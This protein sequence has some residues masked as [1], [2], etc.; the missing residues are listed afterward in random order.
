MRLQ[1]LF[2]L[3]A[4][5]ALP[6]IAAARPASPELMQHVNP[7]GSVTEYRLHGNEYFSYITDAE[8]KNI[9][10]YSNGRLEQAFRNGKALRFQEADIEMLRSEL[11]AEVQ[12]VSKHVGHRMAD[13]VAMGADKGRTTFPTVPKN[14]NDVVRSCVILLEYADKPYSSTDPKEQFTRL[15]NEEGY[16]D[17]GSKGSA[18]DYFKSASN[19]VFAPQFDVYGPVKL[20]HTSAWYTN[21]E[22]VDTRLPLNDKNARFGVAI[23]EAMEALDDEVDFS[24]YDYDN[25]GIIDNIFFFFSGYGQADGGGETTIW[26]HQSDYRRFTLPYGCALDLPRQ[27]RDGVELQCYACSNELNGSRQIP[28]SERPYLDGIGAFCH[29]FGHV[30]GLPDLYD[31]GY[32]GCKTPG[33]YSIMDQGSY[34]DLSTCPPTYS[35]YEQW[36]CRWLEYTDAEDGETY[37]LNPLTQSDR[38]A[39][40]IRVPQGGGS[41]YTEYYVVETRGYDSWDASVPEHGILIWRVNFNY[42]VWRQNKVNSGR[43]PYVELIGPSDEYTAWPGDFEDFVYLTPQ[44]NI[45]VP[46]CLR[47]PL[48]VTL[49]NISYDRGNGQ[50]SFEYNKCTPLTEAPVLAENPQVRPEDR[51]IWLKWDK[52]PGATDYHLTV[53]R[54]DSNDN[55]FTVDGLQESSV[56]NVTEYF[57]KNITTNQWTQTFSAY[58]RP[59]NGVP[60]AV[61]S[62]VINF[63]PAE[64]KTVDIAGVDNVAGE[65][66]VIFGGNG[67]ITAPEGA[68]VYNLSGVECGLTDLPEGVY[69]VVTQGATAKVQVR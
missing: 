51:I 38:N 25:N 21:K 44:M 41:Y 34:N 23:A 56:G 62:N 14:P 47:K 37:Q 9:L 28:E 29:E 58:V 27:V 43:V 59:F 6:L 63:V 12:Q 50:A 35:A 40:R 60:G 61:T 54:R 30:L 3:G 69:I 46:A 1:K 33:R 13:I 16:S 65:V 11:P 4:L 18:R 68:R 2:A 67:C 48:N 10:E 39:V 5:A 20:E 31:T 53:T 24:I 15:C 64:M 7:D 45:L 36:V 26:P 66:P 22:D 49:S 17:Y 52:V 55:V 8:C 19:G 32:N 57:V 42:D